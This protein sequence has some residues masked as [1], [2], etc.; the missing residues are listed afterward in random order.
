VAALGAA[1]ISER[2]SIIR[3]FAVLGHLHWLWIPPAIAAEAASMAAF[4]FMMR[5]LL[6]TGGAR[7]GVR[8][9]LAT[10]FAA[11]ALSVSIPLAGP[12]L[13]TAFTFRR[14]MRLG[15]DAPLAGWSLLA[16]G[17]SPRRPARLSR[18]VAA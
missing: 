9:M 18:L 3:S 16:G 1:T 7:L 5:R 15:A 17:W 13:A 6:A 4:A 11:N 2:A 10:S 14:F 8:P 12:E